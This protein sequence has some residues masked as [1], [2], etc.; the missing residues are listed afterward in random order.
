MSTARREFAPTSDDA[1]GAPTRLV[2]LERSLWV[3]IVILFALSLHRAFIANINWDEFYY[4]SQVHQYRKCMC[5][6]G[7]TRFGSAHSPH[8]TGYHRHNR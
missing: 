4:L 1:D 8:K 6:L 7:R 5:L 3:T 2:L